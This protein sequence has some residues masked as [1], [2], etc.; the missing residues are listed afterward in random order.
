MIALDTNVLVRLLVGDDPEQSRR[1]AALVRKAVARGETLFVSD[2]VLCE[3]AW[4]LASVFGLARE[5]VA[6]SLRELLEVDDL[7]FRDHAAVERAVS[8]FEAGGGDLADFVIREHAR[9][10]G[11]DAVATFDRALQKLPGFTAP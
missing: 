10:A 5:V 6:S 8:A 7:A 3:V 11:C 4:V 9:A 2:V 1:A